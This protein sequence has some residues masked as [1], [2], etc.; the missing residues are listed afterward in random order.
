MEKTHGKIGT[1]EFIAL[2]M[3]T[4]GTKLA[5][6]TPSILYESLGNAAWLG[7]AIIC[8]LSILPLYFLTKLITHFEEKN[9]I[10]I[11]KL[12][13]G[14]YIGFIV[15]FILWILQFHSLISSSA[16]YVDI[17]GSM[18]FTK[19]PIFII[20]IVLMGVAAYGAKKG[21]ESIGSTAWITLPW[22][23]ISLLIVL[24][25]TFFQ[26][27]S[28]FMFPILGPGEMEI[29]KEGTMNASIFAEFF[30][31]ALLA[32]NVKNKR[33]YK[34]GVWVAFIFVSIEFILAFISY[35]MLFD[36]EGVK[37]INYPYHETIRYIQIG[38]IK[39]VESLFFPFWL[40]A[41][42]IRFAVGLY[43]SALLFGS[44]FKVKQFE[45]IVPAISTIVIFLGLIPEAPVFSL[46]YFRVIFLYIVTPII[47]ILPF[48]LWATAIIKGEFKK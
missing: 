3:L 38:F 21:I 31:I 44:L 1:K 26:G 32:T 19:T 48:L 24:V 46:S 27:E 7:M 13:F 12:L 40:V 6:S 11:T 45:Y 16:V 8:I 2:I 28:N 42:Y 20:Y 36:Y 41:S 34:K 25:I 14:R 10:D 23:K 30:F 35:V 4:V 43:I 33:V 9:L 15:L 5:D 29:L 39:N 47:L 18:Y 37:L 22:I 17:I